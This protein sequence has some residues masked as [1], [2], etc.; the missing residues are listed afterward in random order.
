MK[1]VSQQKLIAFLR[2]KL[3][4]DIRWTERAL[5]RIFENQTADEQEKDSVA[6][7]NLIGFTTYDAAF[8]SNVAKRTVCRGYQ[9]SEKQAKYV[10]LAMGKYARQLFKQPYFDREKLEL[11]YLKSI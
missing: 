1:K 6:K 4:S 3:T 11:I 8:L 9:M 10:M 7:H 2:E 5:L